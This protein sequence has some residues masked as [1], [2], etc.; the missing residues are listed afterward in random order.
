MLCEH[1]NPQL[2]EFAAGELSSDSAAQVAAHVEL[3]I[4]CQSDLQA[5][6]QMQQMANNWQETVPPH[7]TPLPAPKR[8]LFEHLRLWFPT[9][10]S[11][12]ALV[13]ASLLYLQTPDTNGALPS[14]S[15]NIAY[16]TLP[17][18]PQATQAAMVESVMQR[19]QAQRQE[20]LQALLRIL[21]AEMDRRSI[22]TEE[23]LRFVISSQ[24]QGQ[25]ELDALYRQVTDLIKHPSTA[26][27]P[28]M[29]SET[30]A[31]TRSRSVNR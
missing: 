10:A 26:T 16:E 20:E 24:L 30:Q 23:S 12:A 3:C 21:K 28:A 7:W 17:P 8:D 31:G 18:L 13:M 15:N 27:E 5:I 11:T 25:R 19:S 1:A 2:I 14:Q 22:E 29:D 4:T 9:A 6:N